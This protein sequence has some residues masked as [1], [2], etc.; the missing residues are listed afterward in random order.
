MTSRR[1]ISRL[2]RQQQQSQW[3]SAFIWMV[4][5]VLVLVGLYFWGVPAFIKLAV[6]YGDWKAGENAVLTEDTIP[7]APPRL[8]IP[9]SATSSAVLDVNGFAEP[10]SEVELL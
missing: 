9:F 6:W 2:D 7:P 8:L 5:S 10:S 4:M 3:R 1:Y